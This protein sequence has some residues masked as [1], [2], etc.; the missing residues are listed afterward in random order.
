M[1]TNDIGTKI[2][3]RIFV[4]TTRPFD[5][6]NGLCSAIRRNSHVWSWGAHA[7]TRM[8]AHCLRFMVNGH[9][10]KGH[11]YLVVNLDDLFDAYL[12]TSRGTIKDVIRDVY[13]DELVMRL[14]DRIE[15]IEAYVR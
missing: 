6:M 1:A 8:N 15:R 12:T 3:H 9:H 4:E 13:I 10:H 14:D 2:D 5:D 11:V 7:W